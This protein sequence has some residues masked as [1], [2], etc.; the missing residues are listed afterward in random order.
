MNTCENIQYKRVLTQSKDLY[1]TMATE[2]LRNRDTV[3]NI[4]TNKNGSPR[5]YKGRNKVMTYA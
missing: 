3:Q 5:K 1:N 2:W 4:L